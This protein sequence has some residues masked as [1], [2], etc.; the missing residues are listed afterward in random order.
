MNLKASIP[1]LTG[2]LTRQRDM[3]AI[4]GTTFMV[5]LILLVPMPTWL[6]DVLLAANIMLSV[7][8]LMTVSYIRSP[9][10]LSSFP[11]I[12]LGV[13]LFRLALNVAT[14]RL[15]LGAGKDEGRAGDLILRFSS[16]VAS[17]D[18][19]SGVLLG[20]IIFM[21]IIIILLRL[22]HL[23]TLHP[24]RKM[25]WSLCHSLAYA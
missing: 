3:I 23:S 2:N 14:T 1:F 22:A 24:E 16:F 17:D 5:L 25:N 12:L 19:L 20:S 11:T 4:L 8:L 7:M 13:T 15:I 21:I 9:L 6:M 18:T 10:E